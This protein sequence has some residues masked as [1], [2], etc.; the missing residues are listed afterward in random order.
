MF[1]L[2]PL[3]LYCFIKIHFSFVQKPATIA[4]KRSSKL[5][6]LMQSVNKFFRLAKKINLK[7]DVL[8][9][10]LYFIFQCNV[11]STTAPNF[12]MSVMGISFFS[13]LLYLFLHQKQ[14]TPNGE[15]K[16]EQIL[17]KV[18]FCCVFFTYSKKDSR[19]FLPFF[20]L[21]FFIWE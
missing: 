8:S 7:G 9:E 16:L 1:F 21:T 17:L 14:A 15:W 10:F 19:F 11:R 20:L 4:T 18:L 13:L 12:L 5:F 3:H 2:F 6:L